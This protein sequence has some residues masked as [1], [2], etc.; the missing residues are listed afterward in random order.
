MMIARSWLTDIPLL[1]NLLGLRSLLLHLA[2]ILRL[3][4]LGCSL[5]A[6]GLLGRRSLI[7]L[8]HDGVVVNL[9]A[10]TARAGLLWFSALF[11]IS[12]LL[13]SSATLLG[14]WSGSGSVFLIL[15]LD[16]RLRLGF[17]GALLGSGSGS[18]FLVFLVLLVLYLRLGLGF[19]GTL[20]GLLIDIFIIFSAFLGLLG[21][22]LLIP[23][24]IGFRILR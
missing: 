7:F 5:P 3:D 24:A 16:L 23:E 8:A 9:L 10:P 21:L 19:A 20:L 11:F 13:G 15:V 2:V 17:A 14:G 12:L 22:G 4:L 18:V 1:W 6:A